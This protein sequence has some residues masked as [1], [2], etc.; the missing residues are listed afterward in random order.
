[1]TDSDDDLVD[2]AEDE[3]AEEEAVEAARQMSD[4]EVRPFRS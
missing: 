2:E 1:M 4:S 3:E